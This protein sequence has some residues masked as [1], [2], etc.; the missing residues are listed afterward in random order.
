VNGRNNETSTFQPYISMKTL[1]PCGGTS[2]GIGELAPLVQP[3]LMREGRLVEVMP[4]WHFLDLSQSIPAIGT[5]SDRCGCLGNSRLRWR[6]HLFTLP[7]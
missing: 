4:K 3:E 5:S 7:N 6:L 1:R 2:L